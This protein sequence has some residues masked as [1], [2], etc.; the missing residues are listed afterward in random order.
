MEGQIARL[1]PRFMG[2]PG[3]RSTSARRSSL[4]RCCSTSLQLPAPVK[5]GKGKTRSTAADVLEALAAENE[6]VRLVLEYRQLT[7]LKGT[8]VDASR[9]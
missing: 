1:T 8:Y 5:Y 7:K 3:G 4:A 6:I 9:R 2:W